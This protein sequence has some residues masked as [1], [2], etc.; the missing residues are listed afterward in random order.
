MHPEVIWSTLLPCSCSQAGELLGLVALA[1]CQLAKVGQG[2]MGM[3]DELVDM[4]SHCEETA[5][6]YYPVP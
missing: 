5:D 4:I 1:L 3:P 6:A 2:I